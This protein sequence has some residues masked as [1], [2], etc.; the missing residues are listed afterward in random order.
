MGAAGNLALNDGGND[1]EH[2]G[3]A[4]NFTVLNGR[5]YNLSTCVAH[6]ESFVAEATFYKMLSAAGVSTQVNCRATGAATAK[7]AG[8]SKIQS[9]SVVCEKD[10]VTATVFIDAR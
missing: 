10:P 8:V 3:L 9:I 7:E 2:T 6:P 1:A 4:Y 5:H